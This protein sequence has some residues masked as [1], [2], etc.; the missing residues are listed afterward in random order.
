MGCLGPFKVG[1]HWRHLP[2]YGPLILLSYKWTQ[3]TQ[4][5]LLHLAGKRKHDYTS[6][7]GASPTFIPK[8]LLKTHVRCQ[9]AVLLAGSLPCECTM[10]ITLT[11]QVNPF[12]NRTSSP[13]TAWRIRR[14]LEDN[15][16]VLMSLQ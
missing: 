8:I 13:L 6:F 2:C 4:S 5:V 1:N 7:Y 14:E 10:W 3:V 9:I 16:L 12:M 15:G 11:G